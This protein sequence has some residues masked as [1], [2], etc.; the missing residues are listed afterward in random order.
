MIVSGGENVYPI[1]VEK[2]AERLTRTSPRPGYWESTDEQYRA[3]DWGFRRA[4]AQAESG[5]RR[6]IL[7]AEG[8]AT[9]RPDKG[10]ARDSR[11]DECPARP[12]R[13]DARRA[14][15]PG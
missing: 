11:V 10:A 14:C 9:P 7:K 3:T 2:D 13:Q 8:A 4:S 12:A 1:E 6:N 15:C 5:H